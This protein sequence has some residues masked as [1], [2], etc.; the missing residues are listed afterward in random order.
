MRK[1]TAILAISVL[2]AITA[3]C[4]S[5]VCSPAHDAHA[6]CPHSQHRQTDSQTCP[7]VLLAKAKSVSVAVVVPTLLMAAIAPVTEHGVELAGL[8]SQVRGSHELYVRHRI[9]LL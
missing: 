9:L 7:F 4:P 3:F 2:V 1:Q 8:P 5:L 6:C